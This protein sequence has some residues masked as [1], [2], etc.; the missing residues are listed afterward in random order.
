MVAA[1]TRRQC[2][3]TAC[4]TYIWQSPR[5]PTTVQQSCAVHASHSSSRGWTPGL[6]C[7][8]L[9][10]EAL[11]A[12]S[13]AVIAV[14]SSSN[15][16]HHAEWNRDEGTA[17]AEPLARP[18]KCVCAGHVMSIAGVR[19]RKKEAREGL[20][21]AVRLA[22]TTTDRQSHCHQS[23]SSPPPTPGRRNSTAVLRSVSSIMSLLLRL[24]R[25][26]AAGQAAPVCCAA[27]ARSSACP[28]YAWRRPSRHHRAV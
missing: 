2:Y 20:L 26:A 15:Y 4:S 3:C 22:H 28:A 10:L 17:G 13:S 16:N 27:F 23:T 1:P 14:F 19:G 21:G 6:A 8:V 18:S 25:S 11:T 5:S 24:A 12:C 9:Q 7:S